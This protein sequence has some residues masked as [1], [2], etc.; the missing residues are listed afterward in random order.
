MDRTLHRATHMTPRVQLTLFCLSAISLI[1]GPL[2]QPSAAQCGTGVALKRI[3]DDPVGTTSS[4]SV[5]KADCDSGA[6]LTYQVNDSPLNGDYWS[7]YF[8]TAGSNCS[9]SEGREGTSDTTTKCTAVGP[10]VQVTTSSFP[11]DFKVELTEE[12]CEASKVT[13]YFLNAE[14]SDFSGVDTTN[15]CRT[16]ELLLDTTPLTSPT[17]LNGGSGENSIKVNWTANDDPTLQ[18]YIVFVDTLP[19]GHRPD[20][21]ASDT[22]ESSHLVSGTILSPES[23]PDSVI[24]QIASGSEVS[25]DTGKLPNDYAAVAV[26][27]RDRSGNLSEL[28]DQAC[29]NVVETRGYWETYKANG[30]EAEAGCACSTPGVGHVGGALPGLFVL[31]GLGLRRRKTSDSRRPS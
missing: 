29:L 20:G 8:T 6:T 5:N 22:C 3:G 9:T 26:A 31:L 15:A 19:S 10:P 24:T 23:L 7:V 11:H 28:S 12:L 13:I 21:G 30:G 4:R 18:D 27:A 1:A 17:G 14:N 25:I 2:I 16:V